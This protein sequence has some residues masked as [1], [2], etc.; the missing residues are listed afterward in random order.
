MSDSEL[1]S[2]R[3]VIRLTGEDRLT[4]LQGII[5]QDMKRLDAEPAIFS[6][7]LT[8]QGK[9]LFDFFMAKTADALLI[10]CDAE[11]APA[12]LKR[13]ALYKLRAKV[14]L[15]I[16]ETLK[17]AASA[18]ELKDGVA[19]RDPRAP[20]LGWRAIVS[21]AGA[22][23]DAYDRRR[24]AAG[25]PEFGS[26]FSSDEM[27]L[28]DV[29]YDALAAV[30]YK[31]GC[32]VGQ[33]VSSRMKRKGEARRRTL[34]ADFEG[35][36]PPKG[37]PV[38]AGD[39]TLGEIMSGADGVALAAIRLDRWEKARTEEIPVECGGRELRLRIPAY[40]EQG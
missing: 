12:L 9:I 40:L 35:A 30:R 16:D 31:K 23:G 22:A 3:A 7:L 24:I 37:S 39:S 10:D 18:N 26:D 4:F 28:L 32:F 29:N 36:P 20:E 25:V 33:E 17:V 13:F 5:T 8:P 1:L 11:T 15:E 21:D 34:V 27:F 38:T 19:F 2:G 14:G 6:A